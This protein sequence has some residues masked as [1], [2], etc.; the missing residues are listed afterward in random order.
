MENKKKELLER[1]LLMMNYDSSK[2][3]NENVQI[4]NE[5]SDSNWKTKYSC[6]TIH[7]GA[8]RMN[9][10]DG[11]TAY[12]I[13][14][15]IY[16]N[17]GRTSG[18]FKYSCNDPF[19]KYPK[20][21]A[22]GDAFRKWFFKNYSKD[23]VLGNVAKKYGVTETGPYNSPQLRKAWEMYGDEYLKSGGGKLTPD[24]IV[25]KEKEKI[26][27]D[28]NGYMMKTWGTTFSMPEAKSQQEWVDGYARYAAKEIEGAIMSVWGNGPD[29]KCSIRSK[30]FLDDKPIGAKGPSLWERLNKKGNYTIG[31]VVTEYNTCYN[32]DV[33]M[34]LKD[35]YR[36]SWDH[37]VKAYGISDIVSVEKI[38]DK[39]Y[40]VYQS[41]VGKISNVPEYTTR[42]I[43]AS[44]SSSKKMGG[45]SRE[46]FHNIMMVLEIASAF[47]PGIGPIL[48]FGFGMTDALFYFDE[49]PELG[50][51]V[52]LLTV[53]PELKLFTNSIKAAKATGVY[54]STLNKLMRGDVKALTSEEISFVKEVKSLVE[55]NK[56]E[57]KAEIKQVVGK[58]A[59]KILNNPSSKK[60]LS[61]EE[62]KALNTVSAAKNLEFLKLDTLFGIAVPFTTKY[63]RDI[64]K[65]I[66][67][68]Y[69]EN[70]GPLT[71]AQWVDL[72]RK[73]NEIP[74]EVMPQ[75][76]A[77]WEE[78]PE[79]FKAY[80]KSEKVS[81]AINTRLQN[82][83]RKV[84]LEQAPKISDEDIALLMAD[85]PNQ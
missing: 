48:S 73:L 60:Q 1:V 5:Q 34:G 74:K 8:K 3:L 28:I 57:V 50:F 62:I 24:E 23:K 35:A 31:T 67:G 69:E 26:G 14:G 42:R 64:L 80:V 11:S 27:S 68:L 61:Q 38:I 9:L 56:G 78:K 15:I 70:L 25:S 29:G 18:K 81:K 22:E 39:L 2:T 33:A 77:A 52:L 47:I 66:F 44:P 21:K 51:F 10:N 82:L 19:F 32:E 72:E 71:E 4:I 17:N 85:E 6:V 84:P 49:D 40:E 79:E 75:T 55:A 65:R 54:S 43:Y 30:T 7:Y 36:P 46:T 45:I 20:N 76:V 58:E 16:Y 12:D 37:V 59:D 83:S 53:A 13:N 63:G 41:G